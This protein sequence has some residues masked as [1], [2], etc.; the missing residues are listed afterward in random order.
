MD[1]SDSDSEY[2]RR[3][4][5]RGQGLTETASR[6]QAGASGIAL[7]VAVSG[8]SV[9]AVIDILVPFH[10]TLVVERRGGGHLHSGIHVV[11]SMG[12]GR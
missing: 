10:V 6:W 11:E 2:Q 8:L 9:V 5:G 3:S 4:R 12:D 1:G 7:A